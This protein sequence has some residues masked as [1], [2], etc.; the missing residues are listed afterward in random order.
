MGSR[1]AVPRLW[2]FPEAQIS[3]IR[4]H[5][6]PSNSEENKLADIIHLAD[7]VAKY[8]GYSAGPPADPDRVAPVIPDQLMIPQLD[9]NDLAGAVADDVRKIEEELQE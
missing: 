2:R 5:H 9:L 3:A 7:G 8:A 4:Y 1:Q 6:Q